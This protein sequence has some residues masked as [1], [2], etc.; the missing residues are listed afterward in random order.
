[1]LIFFEQVIMCAIKKDREKG[2][3]G[4]RKTNVSRYECD[5]VLSGEVFNDT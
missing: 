4:V 5:R 3:D 2:R 1:M